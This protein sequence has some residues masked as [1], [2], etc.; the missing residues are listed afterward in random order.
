MTQARK[1]ETWD[2]QDT[3]RVD[4]FL[5]FFKKRMEQAEAKRHE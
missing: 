1:Q 2:P 5:K 3:E 4:R